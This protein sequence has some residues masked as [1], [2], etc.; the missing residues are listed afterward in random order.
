MN[1]KDLVTLYFER[2]NAM[3][4]LW[5]IYI[6]IVLGLM[7]FVGTAKPRLAII[8]LMLIAFFGFAYVNCG[9]LRSVTNQRNVVANLIRSENKSDTDPDV[10]RQISSTLDPPSVLDVTVF[11]V[12]GD[13]LVISAV[14]FLGFKHAVR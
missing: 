8:F 2:T 13:L 11:H 9:A 4:Y 14:L 12:I 7:G 3:Q 1:F 10:R 5:S 6:T